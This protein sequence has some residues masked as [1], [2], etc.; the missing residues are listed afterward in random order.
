MLADQKAAELTS[1]QTA[2]QALIRFQVA[3]EA[4]QHG[5][6]NAVK[7]RTGDPM[8]LPLQSI[9]EETFAPEAGFWTR[10]F[11]KK[12]PHPLDS[13]PT[14]QTRLDSL[15]QSTA[16]EEARRL[17][18]VSSESAYQ[19]WFST[20]EALFSNLN[21][22][23]RKAVEGFR[24]QH[25][26]VEADPTTEAGRQ[27]LE[28]HFPETKWEGRPVA[29]WVMVS[30]LGLIGLGLI[31]GAVLI[32]LLPFRILFL[33]LFLL[34]ALAVTVVFKRHYKA[35]LILTAQG[36]S[37]S[38]WKRP[39]LFADVQNI[40]AVNSNSAIS[41]T[42]HLK[43]KQDSYNKINLYPFPIKRLQFGLSV[44]AGKPIPIAQTIF[45]YHA[46]QLEN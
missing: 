41:L 9:V 15:G 22:Q 37:Y 14:L 33:I 35:Q 12:L 16:P 32:D 2:A 38:G 31:A 20:R 7:T 36:L 26:V 6:Q 4:F 5:F 13:H 10:L 19:K 1:P 28:Q 3:C 42:F 27:L 23:A 34:L 25:Q 46:R 17:A 18:L 11:E 45:R 24:S 8:N 39:L 43:T 29:F 44:L 21:E 30:L 40:T